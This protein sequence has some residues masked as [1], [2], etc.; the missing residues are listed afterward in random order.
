MLEIKKALIHFTA[1]EKY[2]NIQTV[3]K[4]QASWC[5]NI[6]TNILNT[7][8]H[9]GRVSASSTTC[10]AYRHTT[11]IANTQRHREKFWIKN[12]IPNCRNI[13]WMVA[14][15]FLLHR[16]NSEWRIRALFRILCARNIY[17]CATYRGWK[18]NRK[19]MIYLCCCCC[20]YESI[21]SVA[22][23]RRLCFSFIICGSSAWCER[24]LKKSNIIIGKCAKIVLSKTV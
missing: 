13:F 5:H 3:S 17:V 20:C 10:N 18:I 9:R 7:Y 8:R 21:Y 12:R 6:L 22:A 11:S 1:N 16:V 24:R 14:R 2:I 23:A 19:S 4:I 15:S